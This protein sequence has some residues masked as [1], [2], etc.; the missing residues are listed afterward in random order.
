VGIEAGGIALA[1]VLVG[2]VAGVLV[3]VCLTRYINPSVFGWSL[4]FALTAR[5]FVEA[6]LFLLVVVLLSILLAQKMLRMIV[7]AVRVADE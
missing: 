6:C 7:R 5:P 4:D 3:G 1:A 2:L